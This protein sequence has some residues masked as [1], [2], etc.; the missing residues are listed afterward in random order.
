MNSNKSSLGFLI[1]DDTYFGH[2]GYSLRFNGVEPGINDQ[3]RNRAIVMHG[4]DYVT[5]KR[6]V[7]GTMMGR[8]FG[9]PAVS[10]AENKKIVM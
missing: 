6:S 9:C 8:S 10:A 7:A 1:T 4:S 5:E 2:N 3:V